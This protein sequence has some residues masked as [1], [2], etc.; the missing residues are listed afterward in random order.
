M[1]FW[2]R[3]SF[4]F[5]ILINLLVAFFYPFGSNT[6]GASASSDQIGCKLVLY[7]MWMRHYCSF[8]CDIVYRFTT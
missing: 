6:A 5:A 3:V 8:V 2:S 4:N 7:L 1:S